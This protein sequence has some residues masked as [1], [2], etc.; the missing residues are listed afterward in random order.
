MRM[1]WK[2]TKKSMLILEISSKEL[3]SWSL[4]LKWKLFKR[5]LFWFT[6]PIFGN[7]VKYKLHRENLVWVEENSKDEE[8]SISRHVRGW[9]ARQGSQ[10]TELWVKLACEDYAKVIM[11][12][13]LSLMWRET[14]VE[15]GIKSHKTCMLCKEIGL[16]PVGKW[17]HW[18]LSKGVTCSDLNVS[19]WHL[20]G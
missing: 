10:R 12:G 11:A 14:A 5:K 13:A 9:Q 1:P 19:F 17:E 6:L 15:A 4:L 20:F 2:M 18:I 7:H 16:N 3:E 8:T